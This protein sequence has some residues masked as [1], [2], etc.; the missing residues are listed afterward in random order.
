M[1]VAGSSGLRRLFFAV[2]LADEAR[3]ILAE[4]LPHLPGKVVPPENWHLTTRFLGR[5]D[6][7]TAERLSAAIDQVGLGHSF[8]VRLGEMGAFPRPVR[9]TVLWLTVTDGLDRLEG[10]NS[11][12]E[13]AAQE[14]GLAAENRPFA[15]HLTLSR[16][17]PHRDVRAVIDGYQPV[18]VSWK[19]DRLVLYQ[20]TLGRGGAVYTALEEFEFKVSS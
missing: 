2:P 20:S 16:I 4:A 12:C 13:E 18:P 14:V 11:I 8:K 15:A 9:A 7:V 6:Q 17:R 19:A 3:A 1:V 5:V 10:L